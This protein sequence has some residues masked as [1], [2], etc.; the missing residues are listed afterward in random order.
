[1]SSPEP[2]TAP[3]IH[4][5]PTQ[6]PLNPASNLQLQKLLRSRTAAIRYH[7]LA[8]VLYAV[9]GSLAGIPVLGPAVSSALS[10]WADALEQQAI[11]ALNDAAN[12]QNTANFVATQLSILVGGQLASNVPGGVSISDPFSGPS[13]NNLGSEW[14]RSSNISVD[15]VG[16]GNF[17]P[18][19]SGRAVWKKLGGLYKRYFD[20]HNTPTATDYQAVFIVIAKPVENPSVGADAYTYILARCNSD[21]TTFIYVRIGNN[22]LQIGKRDGGTWTSWR[23]LDITTQPGDQ[24]VLLVGTTADDREIIVRQNGISQAIG[25]PGVYSYTDTSGSEMGPDYRYVGLAHQAAERNL[26]TDQTRPA[27]IDGF[28]ACDRLPAT[29]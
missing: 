22:D 23:T 15:G 5:Y 18:N 13:A 12:A 16:G 7:L 3:G 28:S 24:W 29:V 11:N 8:D 1:M 25:G 6:Q 10:A 19:G 9:S 26:Y 14:T 20:R 21:A 27:E 2:I 4:D 17:G